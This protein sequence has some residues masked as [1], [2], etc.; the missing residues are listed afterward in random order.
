MRWGRFS[1]YSTWSSLLFSALLILCGARASGQDSSTFRLA[2]GG[3][4]TFRAD[5]RNGEALPIRFVQVSGAI[6]VT[7]LVPESC[8]NS[9]RTNPAGMQSAISFLV[10]GTEEQTASFSIQ[11]LSKTGPASVL[12]FTGA[13]QT[14]SGRDRIEADAEFSLAGAEAIRLKRDPARA[15]EALT[16]YDHAIAAWLSIDDKPR[17]AQSQI[18]KAMFLGFSQ[19][20][21]TGAQPLMLDA[22]RLADVLEVA[23]AANCWKVAGYISAGLAKYDSAEMD[24]DN[25]LRLFSQTGDQLNQEII[26]DNKAR[27]ARQL[28]RSDDALANATRAAALALSIG[29]LQRQ[30]SIAE[31]LGSIYIERGELK[32]A[33]DA[34]QQALILLKT[35][36][37]GFVEGYIWSDLGVLYTLI[38][39]FDRARDALDQATAYWQKH[40]SLAGQINTLDDYGDLLLQQNQPDRARVSL[41]QGLNLAEAHALSRQQVFLLRGIGESYLRS[42]PR[43]SQL[44]LDKAL[45]I[46]KQINQGDEL[47]ELYCSLGD[48]SAIQKKWAAARNLYETCRIDAI[49]AKSQYDIIRAEGSLARVAFQS[50]ALEEAL[51]HV[52]IAIG[53]IE[54]MRGHLSEENLKTAFF[55]SMHSYYDLDIA[56]SMGLDKLHPGEGYAWKAFLVAERARSR[57][58]LDQMMAAGAFPITAVSPALLAQHA[59]IT[60]ELLLAEQTRSHLEGSAH[61]RSANLISE[62]VIRLTREEES[63]R[64]LISTRTAADPTAIAE[65]NSLSL[66]SIQDSLLAPHTALL[67][68]WIGERSSFLWVINSSEFH[69]YNLASASVLA[70]KTAILT[71]DLYRSAVPDP[72]IGAEERDSYRARAQ[73]ATNADAELLGSALLPPGSLTAGTRRLLLVQDEAALSVPFAALRYKFP[74]AASLAQ[75]FI[76]VS[77]PSA[78]SLLQLL[79][80]PE[81]SRPWKIAVFANPVSSLTDPRIKG[82]LK[83]A[84]VRSSDSHHATDLYLGIRSA[85]LPQ[86]PFAGQEADFIVSTYGRE[87]TFVMSGFHASVDAFKSLDWSSFTI[88]HFAT[89]A[90]LNQQRAELSGLVLSILDT[91]GAAQGGMLWYGD[92]SQLHLPLDLVVLSACETANGERVPGEGLLGLSHA[93]MAAGSQRVLGTLWKVDDE[94]TADWMRLFYLNLKRSRSPADALHQA[95]LQMSQNPRWHSPYYWAGFTLEGNWHAIP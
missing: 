15:E 83:D 34:Y 1:R 93:F 29:D 81:S 67:E 64:R 71:R 95:Q 8:T 41:N 10:F 36:S 62:R 28:G 79:E 60:R 65:A 14:I 50:L 49:A 19:N 47:A 55:S 69:H 75:L 89:H 7:C 22:T 18:W 90:I 74:K 73:E 21:L 87:N 35:T 12:V 43:Q 11:N 58:L 72:S 53:A 46:A 24:Y 48:L 3:T 45:V 54:S 85:T 44:A 5:A 66:K 23:E 32:S 33:Y 88:G 20:D 16:L 4:Q 68:Y 51:R 76:V 6:S 94:A 92:I 37:Y 56:V 9:T 91:G 52:D 17:L 63:I 40:E 25:A 42:N 57:L 70:Q 39:D 2:P 13:S 26:L 59:E 38:H 84:S 61:T 27:L 82:A 31:E 78:T 77:E 86:L 30:L 80:H